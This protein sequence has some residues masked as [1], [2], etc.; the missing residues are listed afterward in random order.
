MF[1]RHVREEEGQLQLSTSFVITSYWQ[2]CLIPPRHPS[3]TTPRR[4]FT[5]LTTVL[6]LFTPVLSLQHCLS[7]CCQSKSTNCNLSKWGLAGSSTG[8]V[9][10]LQNVLTWYQTPSPAHSSLQWRY[11]CQ[12]SKCCG[13]GKPS[14]G[15]VLYFTVKQQWSGEINQRLTW[16]TLLEYFVINIS[17]GSSR[18]RYNYTG[19]AF[20]IIIINLA[21]HQLKVNSEYWQPLLTTIFS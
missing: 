5:Y 10:H 14:G 12:Q 11:F 6:L 2:T 18:G 20:Y 15:N 19:Q 16:R 17:V 9:I 3:C 21:L 1:P 4:T 13:L 8:P 7:V